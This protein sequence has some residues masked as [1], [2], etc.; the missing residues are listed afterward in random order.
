MARKQAKTDPLNFLHDL[1]A[2]VGTWWTAQPTQANTLTAWAGGP[3]A[4]Q[5]LD[6]DPAGRIDE[7]LAALS[8]AL[9]V[10]R[11]LVDNLFD[12]AWLHDW[13]ADPFSRCA[14]SYPAVGGIPAQRSLAKPVGNTLFFAG[15]AT[16]T[17]QTATVAGALA[18][19]RRAAR[20]VLG[21]SE[22]G[23]RK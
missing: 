22:I 12:A 1:G 13:R 17:E 3:K 8:R 23:S 2:K 9:S 16:N 14:Y 4:E 6:R 10:P 18:S 7:A 21:A 11:A 5:L 20:E 15:E 19:G